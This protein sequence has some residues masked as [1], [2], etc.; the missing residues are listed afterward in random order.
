ML[1]LQ[2]N[3]ALTSPKENAK[4]SCSDHTQGVAALATAVTTATAT[5]SA[6]ATATAAAAIVCDVVVKITQWKKRAPR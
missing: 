4:K 5:A 1:V 3:A 2:R 6:T